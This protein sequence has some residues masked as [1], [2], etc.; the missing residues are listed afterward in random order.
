MAVVFLTLCILGFGLVRIY[1]HPEER[2]FWVAAS[3]TGWLYLVIAF[4][5]PLQLTEFLPSTRITFELW[6]R[7]GV[8]DVRAVFAAADQ[9]EELYNFVVSDFSVGAGRDIINQL[10]TMLAMAHSLTALLIAFVCGAVCS[11]SMKRRLQTA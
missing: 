4:V 6:Y 3:I 1:S 5:K 9:K 7:A 8:E 2:P 11:W 10:Q